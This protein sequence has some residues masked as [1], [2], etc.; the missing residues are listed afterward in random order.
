[1]KTLGLTS[2]NSS[3]VGLK[4]QGSALKQANK[5]TDRQ[6]TIYQVALRQNLFKYEELFSNIHDIFSAHICSQGHFAT[7]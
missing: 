2:S 7:L 1:M 3:L 6:K 5:Q 4:A